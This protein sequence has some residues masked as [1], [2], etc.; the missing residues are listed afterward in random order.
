MIRQLYDA[1]I[2]RMEVN[3]FVSEAALP[4]V[5]D[6]AEIVAAADIFPRLG[7]CALVPTVRHAERAPAAGECFVFAIEPGA[8]AA[9]ALKP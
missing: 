2:R 3:S 1:D 8:Q 7:A 9:A 4:Q 6:A 5:A